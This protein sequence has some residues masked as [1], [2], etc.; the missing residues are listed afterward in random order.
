MSFLICLFFFL[1]ERNN[2]KFFSKIE[3][4]L[5][6]ILTKTCSLICQFLC[7]LHEVETV[8]VSLSSF[9]IGKERIDPTPSAMDKL[10]G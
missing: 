4:I 2:P 9:D 7:F 3:K 1:I 5:L 8:C 6:I 10:A